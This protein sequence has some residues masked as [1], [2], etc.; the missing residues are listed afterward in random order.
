M[1]YFLIPRS[2]WPTPF[3]DRVLFD[4]GFFFLQPTLLL[5]SAV[6]LPF[7]AIPFCHSYYDVIWPQPAGLLWTCCLFLSQWLNMVIWALYYI[8]CGLFCPIYFLLGI[9]GPFA[10][11][12]LSYYTLL[13]FSGGSWM[14]TRNINYTKS[15]TKETWIYQHK[16][17]KEKRK[18]KTKSKK[19]NTWNFTIVF[20]EDCYFEIVAWYL[21]YQS[22]QLHLFQC[23]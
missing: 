20:Y 16:T 12:K 18:K 1:S 8:A 13:L 6:L 21:H 19:P 10:F 22:Y 23:I 5:L 14:S 2:F 11:L 4:C 15:K 9:L 3:R 17:Q 7:L